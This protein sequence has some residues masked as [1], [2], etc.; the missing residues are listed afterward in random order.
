MNSSELAQIQSALTTFLNP[1]ASH[2]LNAE[3]IISSVSSSPTFFNSLLVFVTN[4]QAS[5][6]VRLAASTLMAKILEKE[7]QTLE[8][9]DLNSLKASIVGIVTST[10]TPIRNQ[11]EK[12]MEILVKREYPLRWPGLL[13]QVVDM[14]KNS[15]ETKE[16]YGGLRVLYNIFSAFKRE[17]DEKRKPLPFLIKQVFP[18]LEN[19]LINGTKNVSPDFPSIIN[20]LIK[21]FYSTIYQQL[22]D[23]FSSDSIKIW[24]FGAK[25]VIE[26]NP[27]NFGI[28]ELPS[29]WKDACAMDSHPFFKMQKNALEL[30]SKLAFHTT[31]P[32][33]ISKEVL[34][35][36]HQALPTLLNTSMTYLSQL[37]KSDLSQSVYPHS[38][39]VTAQHY[40]FLYYVFQANVKK[41][42]IKPEAIQIIVFDVLVHHLSMQSYE[43]EFWAEDQKQYFFALRN[44][45]NEVLFRVK[46]A[47]QD[48]LVFISKYDESFVG[49]Y[50]GF[51]EEAV[52]NPNTQNS[53]LEGL[54]FGLEGILVYT[55]KKFHKAPENLFKRILF[56]YIDRKD[57]LILTRVCS[58]IALLGKIGT[59]NPEIVTKVCMTLCYS[60]QSESIILNLAALKALGAIFSEPKPRECLQK[61]LPHILSHA[62][63]LLK[64][65]NT[66]EVVKALKNLIS[67]FSAETRQFSRGL[68]ERLLEA[69][70]SLSEGLGEENED[71]NDDIETIERSDLIES[72]ESCLLA[73]CQIL[74]SDIDPSDYLILQPSVLN[75]LG[76]CLIQKKFRCIF[77][78]VLQLF[79]ALLARVPTVDQD[80]LFFFAPITYTLLGP[81]K[82]STQLV[83]TNLQESQLSILKASA[84]FDHGV[85]FI[86]YYLGFFGNFIKKSPSYFLQATD[87]FGNPL[88]YSI[89]QI[90]DLLIRSGEQDQADLDL[91]FAVKLISYIPENCLSL[92][93]SN[94]LIFENV[95]KYYTG[96][97]GLTRGKF[98][99]KIVLEKICGIMFLDCDFFIQ[100]SK[101]SN[102]LD[103][104]IYALFGSLDLFENAEDKGMVILAIAGLFSLPPGE[105]PSIIPMSSLVS[106]MIKMLVWLIDYEKNGK[107]TNE[108]EE[109]KDGEN[110]DPEGDESDESDESWDE[111]NYLE[112]GEEIDYSD[113]LEISNPVAEL[114]SVLGRIEKSNNQ[115]FMS[116][117]SE[118]K[119]DDSKVLEECFKI[120]KSKDS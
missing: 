16:L 105:F 60:I 7:S 96:F 31:H 99:K 33:R 30:L 81:P 85:A 12:S 106:E 79:V 69:F 48:A 11:I 4:E 63:S 5:P 111:E 52:Q 19:L 51:M 108:A 92:L 116:I 39:A 120:F 38:N 18:F 104:F 57:P 32:E 47:A 44:M 14:I 103:G 1:S 37:L 28:K 73:L 45:K 29:K 82:Q 9:F 109:E 21:I 118:L 77:D 88:I 26:L 3:Q 62:M 112:E 24:M 54:L 15:K 23:S 95:L 71:E 114:C 76:N 100:V 67:S 20:L 66:D 8:K 46:L 53:F 83:Q 10:H 49:K 55:S 89:F 34:D 25:W 70:W 94:V 97:L 90:A 115:F 87:P 86:E 22:E 110:S 13:D 72:I 102:Y 84:Q 65:E 107:S 119:G 117:A 98:L 50:L 2:T 74:Y 91:I 56:P 75:L 27:A 93:K 61:D 40:K 35:C 43:R 101:K 113:S 68:F 17:V 59:E 64:S 42:F 58:I 6:S 41:E 78:K 80:I 36:I